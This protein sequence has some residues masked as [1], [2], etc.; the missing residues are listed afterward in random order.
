M[1]TRGAWRNRFGLDQ[2]LT[3][4]M[5]SSLGPVGTRGL[6]EDIAHVVA[7]GSYRNKEF[8]RDLPIGL[9]SGD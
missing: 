1:S 3:G 9:A 2:T 6:I 7:R 4:G 5:G 8:F